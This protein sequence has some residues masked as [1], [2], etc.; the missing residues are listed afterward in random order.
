[1]NLWKSL[2]CYRCGADAGYECRGTAGVLREQPHPD[3]LRRGREEADFWGWVDEQLTLPQNN[4][5]SEQ[6]ILDRVA[7]PGYTGR[8]ARANVPRVVRM[9][10]RDFR[11]AAA[12]DGDEA[13]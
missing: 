11:R 12:G 8:K 7:V 5:L 9:P 4:G 1:M 6:Q 13:A 2:P 10:V 3:R